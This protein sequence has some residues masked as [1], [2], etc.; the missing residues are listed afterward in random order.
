MAEEWDIQMDEMTDE[1]VIDC[2]RLSKEER[3]ARNK[4][5]QEKE[6]AS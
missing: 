3:D 4:N 5:I 2:I 1:E 6:R